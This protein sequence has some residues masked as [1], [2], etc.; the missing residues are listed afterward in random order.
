[1]T[2]PLRHTL[3]VFGI[4]LLAGVP[5]AAHAA[6]IYL[7]PATSTAKLGDTFITTVRIDPQGACVNAVSVTL[8]YPTDTLRA[9]DFS[10]GDSI[11]SLWVSDPVID[12]AAG[13]VTFEGGIPG[14]YCGHIQGD[15]S[16][17]NALGE[18]VFTV[19][20]AGASRAEISLS[21]Q[22]SAYLSDGQGTKA[23]LTTSDASVTLAAE[24][25]TPQNPW[26]EEIAADNIPPDPFTVYLESDSHVFGGNYFVVFSTVDKQSGL[27]HYEILEHGTW[28]RVTSPYQLP[29]Q[30]PQGLRGVEVRAI[31]KAGN[32]EL[33]TLST[34]TPP[35][36]F[37][38]S[39][40]FSLII[41]AVV[42]VLAVFAGVA[43]RRYHERLRPPQAPPPR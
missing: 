20:G 26:L 39:D 3:L 19:V 31:D 35:R 4:L 36:Q 12:T 40:V 23:P 1:M 21:P 41:I 13:T 6:S 8:N 43:M 42:V 15:T 17:S 29:D 38:G 7:D 11:L 37:A 22:T 18:V 16:P 24:A 34:S 5:G 30:S 28:R 32:I 33:G 14:G 10:R 27:D 25:G 2:M 9:V